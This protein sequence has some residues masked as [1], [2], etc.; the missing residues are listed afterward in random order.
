[1]KKELSLAISRIQLDQRW[2]NQNGPKKNEKIL[3]ADR[4]NEEKNYFARKLSVEFEVKQRLKEYL[5][6]TL[7]KSSIRN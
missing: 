7:D 6:T 5:K 3:G 1:M 4:Y 2:I